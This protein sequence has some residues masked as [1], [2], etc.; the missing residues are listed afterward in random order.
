[1]RRFRKAVLYALVVCVVPV[2]ALLAADALSRAGN[3]GIATG[4]SGPQPCRIGTVDVGVPVRV[5]GS[6]GWLSLATLPTAGAILLFWALA[7]A[8]RLMG[9]RRDY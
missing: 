6:V 5:L 8:A 2:L 3:C 7:E 4:A 1:M 9:K